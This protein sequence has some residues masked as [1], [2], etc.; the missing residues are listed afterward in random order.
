[1]NEQDLE[2]L[3]ADFV[4]IAKPMRHAL[5]GK[6]VYLKERLS[7]LESLALESDQMQLREA[8]A[9]AEQA[10]S[11]MTEQAKGLRF[12]A[13]MIKHYVCNSQGKPIFAGKS[14]E[15]LVSTID[16]QW[17]EDLYP[18]VMRNRRSVTLEDAEKNS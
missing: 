10:T 5:H 14:A 1:M 13:L 7:A 18:L 3:T 4:R 17:L 8:F 2:E 15:E 12:A 11:P 6:A 16:S 9:A